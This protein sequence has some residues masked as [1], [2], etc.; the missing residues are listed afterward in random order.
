MENENIKNILR[1]FSERLEDQSHYISQLQA[2]AKVE[3]LQ[4]EKLAASPSRE[5]RVNALKTEANNLKILLDERSRGRDPQYWSEFVQEM[6]FRE[7]LAELEAD[8]GIQTNLNAVL[9]KFIALGITENTK[10]RNGSHFSELLKKLNEGL[11]RWETEVKAAKKRDHNLQ[12]QVYKLESLERQM[13]ALQ[14]LLEKKSALNLH[15]KNPMNRQPEYINMHPVS[16]LRKSNEGLKESRP[17]QTLSNLGIQLD[18]S[19]LQPSRSKTNQQTE[20]GKRT[21]EVEESGM[22]KRLFHGLE[23]GKKGPEESENHLLATKLKKKGR[24]SMASEGDNQG[25]S[26]KDT[27][28]AM[29]QLKMF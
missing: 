6:L 2:L 18:S 19:P 12:G 3:S 9:K 10:L 26:E 22:K 11:G 5:E 7:S 14:H 25:R 17:I 21:G 29:K 16:K 4:S 24:H 1:A 13:D 8:K 20:L 15:G 27:N 23:S 28:S